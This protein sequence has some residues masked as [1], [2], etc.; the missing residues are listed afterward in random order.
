MGLHGEHAGGPEPTCPQNIPRPAAQTGRTWPSP[1]GILTATPAQVPSL[2]HQGSWS[3]RREGP[4]QSVPPAPT[5]LPA[6]PHSLHSTGWLQ[7]ASSPGSKTTPA[8]RGGQ[9]PSRGLPVAQGQGRRAR[10]PKTPSQPPSKSVQSLHLR[11]GRYT[12]LGRGRAH[13]IRRATS[14]SGAAGNKLRCGLPALQ[15]SKEAQGQL[16]GAGG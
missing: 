9:P 4:V 14:H 10:S 16:P 1:P 2:P 12:C 13:H 3:P 5:A 8:L 7:A 6:H 15:N 11:S